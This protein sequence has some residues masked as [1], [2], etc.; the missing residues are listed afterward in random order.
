LISIKKVL[1]SKNID[2]FN[3]EYYSLALNEQLKKLK[4]QY[5]SKRM[6]IPELR[7]IEYYIWTLKYAENRK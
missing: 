4:N 1:S 3:T 2:T 7:E 5:S 6:I